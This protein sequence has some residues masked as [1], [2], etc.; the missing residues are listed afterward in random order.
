MP[1]PFPARPETANCRTPA[2]TSLYGEQQARRE[3]HPRTADGSGDEF[4]QHRGRT[5][6]LR[7]SLSPRNACPYQPQDQAVR[8]RYVALRKEGSPQQGKAEPVAAHPR[9]GSCCPSPRLTGPKPHLLR[10]APRESGVPYACQACGIE[11]EWN[12]KPKY[13]MWI[14]STG[15]GW[16]TE[17]RTFA[18][19]VRIATLRLRHSQVS[20]KIRRGRS[21]TAGGAGLRHLTVWVRVPPAPQFNV[22]RQIR[23]I[24]LSRCPEC[25][26][27]VG[28]R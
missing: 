18:F 7:D 10:R 16:T 9:R 27:A 6:L 19:S 28:P 21:P 15:T 20:S 13:C 25:G 1:S 2:I 17:R 26:L 4:F 22:I 24:H 12:G 11:A 3:I 5:A 23:G 8:H 14:I